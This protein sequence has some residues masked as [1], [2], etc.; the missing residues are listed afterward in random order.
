MILTLCMIHIGAFHCSSALIQL[1]LLVRTSLLYP[2]TY[3]IRYQHGLIANSFLGGLW[4]LAPS[5]VMI[6]LS[7]LYAGATIHI[8][9]ATLQMLRTNK[10]VQESWKHR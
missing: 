5:P 8:Y 7:V 3:R 4:Y 10:F 2:K 9:H 1:A 6:L